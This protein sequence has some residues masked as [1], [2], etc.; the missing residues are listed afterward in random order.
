MQSKERE[1]RR[2][3]REEH[4]TQQ[5]AQDLEKLNDLFSQ[6]EG[7]GTSNKVPWIGATLLL[8]LHQV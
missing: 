4:A 7:E 6:P 8:A 1:E 5:L 3:K 2:R